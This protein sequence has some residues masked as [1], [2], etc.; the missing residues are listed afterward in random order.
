MKADLHIHTLCSDGE[1]S[2]NEILD[3]A[4]NRGIDMLSITDHDSVDSYKSIIPKE[5]IEVITGIEFS[6]QYEDK[7]VHVLGYFIDIEN[8]NLAKY[9]KS[10]RENRRERV[11]KILKKLKDEEIF[12]NEDLI[13]TKDK[14][15]S[16]GRLKIA[17]EMVRLGYV[18]N[19]AEAFS[20][21]I[22]D[23]KKCYVSTTKLS[24]SEAGKL[25]HEAGGL[26]II[27]HPGL[28]NEFSDYEKLLSFNIDGIEVFHPKHSNEQREFFYDFA[29]KND[30]LITGGSDFH[31]YKNKSK[32]GQAYLEDKYIK[33]MYFYRENKYVKYAGKKDEL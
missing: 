6:C 4:I 8:E 11:K 25:I 16:V 15:K 5:E 23:N 10:L 7:N 29:I 2:I 27:A 13:F 14:N 28:I 33:N 17:Q 24:I 31:S 1:Y 18:K 9:L 22:G 32:L 21:Y 20:L 19:E 30:L 26:A 3:M 12:L